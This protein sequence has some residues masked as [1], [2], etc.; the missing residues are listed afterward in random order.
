MYSPTEGVRRNWIG[1]TRYR[2]PCKSGG[3]TSQ[4][5][6]RAFGAFGYHVVFD[7]PRFPLATRQLP[8]TSSVMPQNLTLKPAWSSKANTAK[9]ALRLVAARSRV[10]PVEEQTLTRLELMAALLGARHLKWY[11]HQLQLS[12]WSHWS[13]SNHV[14]YWL[15]LEATLYAQ[16]ISSHK[17]KISTVSPSS[18]H[19]IPS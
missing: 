6:W 18:W 5:A 12:C 1:T 19:H 17:E 13:D 16:F 3:T 9:I 8:S 15:C 14:F 11:L 7:Q 4:W 10:V 2:R